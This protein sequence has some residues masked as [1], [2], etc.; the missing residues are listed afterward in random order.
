MLT[1][2][3]VTK[4]FGA[5]IAVDAVSL[6]VERPMMVGVIGRSGAGKST[7]LRM[8]NLLERPSAGAIRYEGRE[9]TALRGPPRVV[10]R[11]I[12]R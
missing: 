12:A 6:K 1:I 9:V 8:L 4:R 5:A 10:G 3:G 7:L 2:D 11:P